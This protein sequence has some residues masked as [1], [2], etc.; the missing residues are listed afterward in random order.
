MC[1]GDIHS[2]PTSFLVELDYEVVHLKHSGLMQ[3][4]YSL[5]RIEGL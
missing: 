4:N 2:A 1:C 5:P 3:K